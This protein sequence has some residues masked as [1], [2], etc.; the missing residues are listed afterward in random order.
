MTSRR[1]PM[2]SS[3]AARARM[4]AARPR[5]TEPELALRRSL[6]SRGL[7]YRIDIA[8]VPQSQSRADIAFPRAKVAV[9]VDGCFWHSCPLHGTT[10]K[11][12]A[13]WW[14]AKLEANR[15]R[16]AEA[17]RRLREAGWHVE[18][19]WEHESPSDAAARIAAAVETRSTGK[20]Q[21][22]PGD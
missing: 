14:I 22:R 10:P 5:D 6:F 11:A 12:N 18:R 7:R 4:H 9:F 16:D 3:A 20:R 1:T 17:S 21:R 8:L 19:V 15:Q 13:S 2:P